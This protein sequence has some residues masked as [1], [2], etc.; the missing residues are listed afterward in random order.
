M[1]VVNNRDKLDWQENMTVND[2]LEK[3]KY[4]FRLI[5]VTV[6]GQLVQKE[7]Y[8]SFMVPDNANVSA[9]HLAHGG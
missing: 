5:T 2:V 9:F 4:T 6:N 3:M 8:D 1:I 7:D